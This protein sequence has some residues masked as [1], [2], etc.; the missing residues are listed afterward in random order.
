MSSPT[1]LLVE[2]DEACAELFTEILQSEGHVVVHASDET[3]ALGYLRGGERPCMML[4][5]WSLPLGN[6]HDLIAA[7]EAEFGAC[8]IPIVLI[9]ADG[10][11]KS[12]ALALRA[13]GYL[14]KPTEPLELVRM[15][16]GVLR[17]SAAL[18]SYRS[19]Q[20]AVPIDFPNDAAGPTGRTTHP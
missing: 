13:A 20:P 3:S 14:T 10:E 7:I 2:D 15:V 11:A 6:A 1:I 12:K 18:H 19:V 8:D 16:D 9:T 4:L 5:D 17:E